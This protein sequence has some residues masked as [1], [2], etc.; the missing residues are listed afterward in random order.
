V[1][2]LGEL[3]RIVEDELISQLDHRHMNMDVPFLRGVNPTSENIVVACWRVLE[4]HLTPGRLTRLRLHETEN[5]YVEYDG[6]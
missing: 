2:D 4:P 1:I 3:R 6:Q 5:N